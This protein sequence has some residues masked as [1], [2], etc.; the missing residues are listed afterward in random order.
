MVEKNNTKWYV[1][2]GIIIIALVILIIYV[3][4]NKSS[5]PVCNSPYILVGSSCC[6]DSNSNSICDT[7]EQATP[8][9]PATPSCGDGICN[10]NEQAPDCSDC[11]ANVRIENLKYQ[12]L[13]PAG[14]YKEFYISS[15]DLV[16]LGDKAVLYP[17]FDLYTGYSQQQCA[18]KD[19]MTS[20]QKDFDC[21]G[22]C[23]FVV[24]SDKKGLSYTYESSHTGFQIEDPWHENPICM[25]FVFHLK[26]YPQ[27]GIGMGMNPQPVTTWESPIISV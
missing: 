23:Y 4:S 14:Q 9:Q 26:P 22:G 7:D 10:G 13:T 1:I 18:N 20:L 25:Y 27:S 21:P 15:Y 16:Q 12:I 24:T 3:N 19:T 8:T 2:G 5:G 6:L 17:G 11:N